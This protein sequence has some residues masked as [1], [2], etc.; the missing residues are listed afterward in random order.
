MLI[1]D[2]ARPAQQ[3]EATESPA[4]AIQEFTA[5]NVT[6]APSGPAVY[7]LFRHNHVVM[8]GATR[9]LRNDLVAHQRGD[10]GARTRCAT[11]YRAEPTTLD[12]LAVRGDEV[13][14]DYRRSHNSNVPWGN[15]PS[16]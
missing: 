13:M 5:A 3:P 14:A 11:R 2:S 1:H 8:I 15:R 4:A 12:R 16:A 9:H 10:R 6:A 7:T